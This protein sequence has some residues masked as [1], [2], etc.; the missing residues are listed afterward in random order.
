MQIEGNQLSHCGIQFWKNLHLA[1]Y[2]RIIQFW[3]L[4]KTLYSQTRYIFLVW[5]SKDDNY[6]E[7]NADDWLCSKY[8]P[9]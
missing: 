9:D 5:K 2:T 1:V 3:A 7:N 6:D 4:H 8:L